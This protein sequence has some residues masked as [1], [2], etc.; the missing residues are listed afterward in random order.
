MGYYL[1]DF[2]PSDFFYIGFLVFL[3]VAVFLVFRFSPLYGKYCSLNNVVKHRI[4][5]FSVTTA[6]VFFVYFNMIV[7]SEYF[8]FSDIGSDTRETYLPFYVNTVENIASGQFGFWNFDSGLGLSTFAI[9]LYL[10]DPFAFLLILPGG[11]LLGSSS[12]PVLLLC[13]QMLKIY[14]CVFLCD[15]FLSHFKFSTSA[16]MVGSFLYGFSGFLM[17]WGSHYWFGTACVFL[18]ALLLSFESF[19]ESENGW[20]SAVMSLLTALIVAWSVYI[21]FMIM[22]FFVG[23]V[24][25]RSA[26]KQEQF[27]ARVF[28]KRVVRTGLSVVIGCLVGAIAF[29]P[30]VWALMGG[31]NRVG[32]GASTLDRLLAAAGDM[33]SPGEWFA[34]L[35]RMMSN[36]MLSTGIE[37][38]GISGTN[39]YEFPQLATSVTVFVCLALFASYLL[40]SKAQRFRKCILW[41]SLI[42]VFLYCA[43]GVLPFF[44]YAGI[45][46]NYR[47]SFLMVVPIILMITTVWDAA[48]L[49]KDYHFI[50]FFIGVFITLALI[51]ISI[52]VASKYAKYADIA[53]LFIFMGFS[54][55]AVF[56]LRSKKSVWLTVMTVL[57]ISGAAFDAFV[58]TN[59][60]NTG[61]SDTVPT[62]MKTPETEETESAIRY[63]KEKDDTLYRVEKL[64]TDITIASDSLLQDYHG[65]TSYN[66]S[67]APALI[68]F[69]TL[70]WP[71]AL[72]DEGAHQKMADDADQPELASLLNIKYILSREQLDVDWL[73]EIQK[74][75]K[76]WVYL[77]VNAGSIATQY[78]DLISK[79][80]FENLSDKEK[81]GLLANRLIVDD[82]TYAKY[83]S[84]HGNEQVEP[85]SQL[86]N[87]SPFYSKRDDVV[88][89]SV[90]VKENGFL[91][92]AIPDVSGW[93]VYVDNQR[94]DT[95]NADYGFIGFAIDQ[96]E[97]EI[98]AR[99]IPEGFLLGCVVSIGGI[100]LLAARLVFGKA[101][102]KSR[103]SGPM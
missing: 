75:G 44:F 100:A 43:N 56:L 72:S 9:Q 81:A 95:F 25:L 11:V 31:T 42:L 98:T 21:G 70:M 83:S 4:V 69:Y 10:L 57:V 53:Q 73:Q 68:D 58:T 24:L 18:I 14:L 46:V 47:S 102:Q 37:P 84:N 93:E 60:R 52:F 67:L 55:S 2:S 6:A 39:Y 91:C 36:N 74:F 15:R 94:V 85:E 87:S 34:L 33:T 63:L 59:I 38:F 1:D 28:F 66:S 7:G 22:L 49:K 27:N 89:G 61:E 48:F 20:R 5:L 13:A 103:Q 54:V 51:V 96:G 29:L 65:M 92:L 79:S 8:V 50:P 17:L 71:G 3:Y 90:R 26:Y 30:G 41:T 19:L 23:Y 40:K 97:H 12:V 77:N 16:R 64:Y 76:V 78:Q 88:T 80:E 45:T 101:R 99:F 62:I 82:D 35:G 86:E 32:Y